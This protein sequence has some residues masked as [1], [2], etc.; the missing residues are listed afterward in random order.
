MSKKF[1]SKKKA[2]APRKSS[3]DPDRSDRGDA[4]PPDISP[5]IVGIGASAGGL[6]AYKQF[7]THMPADTDMA[8]VLVQH[9][10]PNHHSMLAELLGRATPMPVAEAADGEK[11]QAGHV[12][13]I[14]PDAT[15]TVSDGL[16]RVT[17]PAPPR[18]HRWPIDA[19]F[20][21][22]AEEH[23]ERAVCVVL[24]GS[25]SDGARGLRVVKEHGGLTL[26]QAGFDHVAMTGMP[27]SAEATGLVDQVLTVEEMPARLIAH[28]QNLRTSLEKQGDDG[29]RGD[30]ADNLH[31]ICNLLRKETSHDFSQYKEKTLAR[32]IQRRMQVVQTTSVSDYIAYLRREPAESELL[33]HELLINVTEFFRDR[34]AFEALASQAI[35]ALLAGKNASDTLRVWVPGC[36]TGEEAY[37]IAIALQEAMPKGRA[38]PK[39]MIFATDIDDHA[40]EI[41]RAGRYRA[42]LQGISPERRKRWFVE[43]GD[44]FVVAKAIRELCVFSPHSVLKDP[45][46]SKLDLISCRNLLIYLNAEAQ[47]RLV[48]M[49]HYALKSGGFLLLGTSESVSRHERL[50]K[51]LDKKQRLYARRDDGQ[52]G[53]PTLPSQQPGERVPQGSGRAM[54]TGRIAGGDSVERDARR[55]VEKH[56][57]A[58]VVVDAHRDIVRFNGDT[59]RYLGPSSGA[60]SLNLFTLLHKG[61]RNAARQ[62][63]NQAFANTTSA[64]VESVGAVRDG[65]RTRLRI[66]VEP[67]PDYRDPQSGA[68]QLC[69]VSFVELESAPVAEESAG[70]DHDARV[71]ALEHELE[72][73]RT[74]LQGAI[75]AAEA[76]T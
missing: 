45:P 19:L 9:L 22:L 61:L 2:P 12:Y 35:P 10:S 73:T 3:S 8:F 65:R 43:D 11:L 28:Y 64:A 31:T 62:A 42:P 52:S 66:I 68:P 48:R 33:F 44:D 67:L 30:V 60:A 5:L 76:A 4:G 32:R 21:S 41:A 53:I 54:P 39:V 36:A 14:P 16:L 71:H 51:P 27:A 15:L 20:T 58:W 23:G 49:F 70:G 46:F 69:V 17:K 18:Q 75:D 7:F 55:A 72:T 6:E 29:T 59:G 56:A 13:V 37:S 47:Q 26:A 40:I 74:Q 50:F 57:P 34:D 1:V 24:S 38:R 63:V 25:G